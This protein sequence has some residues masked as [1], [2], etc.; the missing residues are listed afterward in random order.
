ML[1]LTIFTTFDQASLQAARE[2]DVSMHQR[3]KDRGAVR[4]R[5]T[6]GRIWLLF[7][8]AIDPRRIALRLAA[9]PTWMGYAD[10]LTSDTPDARTLTRVERGV[11]GPM[12]MVNLEEWLLRSGASSTLMDGWVFP[13]WRDAVDPLGAEVSEDF[14][15]FLYDNLLV[16]I[17][18]RAD[19][20]RYV[21]L[22]ISRTRSEVTSGLGGWLDHY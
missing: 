9:D 11:I 10:V 15:R 21:R 20:E 4:S 8:A 14:D 1:V 19:Y 16:G 18:D 13:R 2:L 3:R 5:E 17:W 22:V 7:E 12:E 6:E